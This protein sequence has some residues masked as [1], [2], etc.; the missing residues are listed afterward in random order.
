MKKFSASCVLV[1]TAAACG[2]EEATPAPSVKVIPHEQLLALLPDLP[3]WTKGATPQGTTDP[4]E[5][6][7]RVQ[8][9]YEPSGAD[10]AS[11][12]SIEIMD[13]TM[14]ANILGPLRTSLKA[15]GSVTTGT[16]SVP[17]TTTVTEV[18]GFPAVTEWTP[19]AKNGTLTVLVADRFT[20]GLTGNYISGT[21]Q[22]RAVAAAMDLKK[23][24]ALK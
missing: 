17:I 13:T 19:E 11:R 9:D 5:A 24:A 8:V 3:G 21:E 12:L 20:V 16:S 7:S 18:G 15:K 22:L 10:K 1:L 23:L 2:G 6:V 4:A 14:N